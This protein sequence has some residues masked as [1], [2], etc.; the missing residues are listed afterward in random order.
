MYIQNR[1]TGRKVTQSHLSKDII[2][3]ATNVRSNIL[4][5]KPFKIPVKYKVHLK[6]VRET[7]K[8]ELLHF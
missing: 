3:E 2:D 7:Q 1:D 5:L 6:N 4:N 8:K